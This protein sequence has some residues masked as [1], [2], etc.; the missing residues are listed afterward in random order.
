MEDYEIIKRLG[1][2]SFADVYQ[3]KEKST[4]D[5]VAIKVLK[6]K[7]R[8]F[9]DCCELREIKSLQKLQQDSLSNEK[10]VDNI[11]K[12]KQI[13]FD[14]K[15][16]T[17]NI[18][19]EYMETDLYELMKKRAPQKLSETEI[20]DITYQVLLGLYHMHKYG[21]FH[22]DMKPENLLLTGKKIKIADFGLAREIRSIPPYTEYVSTRYYRAPECILRS[23]NY[24]SPIDIWAL[25]CIL[26]EMYMHPMPLFYGST[27]KEVFYKICSILGSP[28]NN[29]WPE[30]INQANLI[31]MK[32]PQNHGTNLKNIVIGASDEAIDLM[33]KMLK[34]D[35]NSRETASNLLNH[36]FFNGCKY[37]NKLINSTNFFSDFGDVKNF[38]KTN[39]RF[40]PNNDEKNDKDNN[41][42]KDKDDDNFNKLLNDT[43]GFNKLLNQLKKEE[44]ENNKNYEKNKNKNLLGESFYKRHLNINSNEINNKNNNEKKIISEVNENDSD[45][46]DNNINSKK[47][48]K[49]KE[50]VDELDFLLNSN[51]NIRNKDIED[52]FNRDSN[53]GQSSK[54]DFIFNDNSNKKKDDDL[55]DEYF[56][57]NN[58]RDSSNIDS[59]IKKILDKD[60]GL[61]SNNKLNSFYKENKKSN[62]KAL[63]MSRARSQIN[64]KLLNPQNNQYEEQSYNLNSIVNTNRRGGGRGSVKY[65]PNKN[66]LFNDNDNKSFNINL[67][68]QDKYLFNKELNPYEYK[69]KK[70]Q[71]E[72]NNMDNFG[73]LINRQNSYCVNDKK[74]NLYDNNDSL[75]SPFRNKKE[76][77]TRFKK[78][79]LY[80]NNN[81]NWNI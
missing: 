27:E 6:K 33:E 80:E 52:N 68:N 73:E 70:S 66:S 37:E 59:E 8:K 17:L 21:F 31:G 18:V 55:F 9:E 24:N 43:E 57:K 4:G 36:P 77:E 7:Y 45:S 26:A 72:F 56:K 19:F 54:Y 63:Q 61:E 64:T 28:N 34:W 10:G 65:E 79:F 39:R 2:G 47:E 14:K 42:N 41:K 71:Y 40:R 58:E 53:K 5:L 29:I 60:T 62:N 51:N 1:G 13:I 75:F 81:Y 20:K 69:D 35:P 15:T 30:G 3:A 23:T 46:D 38:N 49:K 67:N 48:N 78:N 44:S 32:I 16:G 22:R 11:I 12:L 74:F 76:E 50:D 25:G